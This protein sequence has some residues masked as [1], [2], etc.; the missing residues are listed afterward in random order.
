[1]IQKLLWALLKIGGGVFALYLGLII[2]MYVLQEKLLFLPQPADPQ[3]RR[4][5]QKYQP[6]ALMTTK[7]STG[8]S[9]QGVFVHGEKKPGPLWIYFGGNAEN[10]DYIVHEVRHLKD[11]SFVAFNYRGYGDS[12][13]SPSQRAL[14]QDALHIYD[15]FSKKEGVDPTQIYVIGRSL[16]TGMATYLA[17]HRKVKKVVLISP[18]SSIRDVAQ[19]HYPFLPVKWLIRHPF[20]SDKWAKKVDVPLLCVVA[21][22]DQV[23]PR[24]FSEALFAAW[25]GQKS[26]KLVK[27][28]DH[29][30]IIAAPGH[31]STIQ[32][33]LQEDKK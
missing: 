14:Y 17:A 3:V 7:T 15:T 22:R 25:K 21:E 5:L 11:A 9:L 26:M 2:L 1:M 12:E 28:Y 27:G 23:V 10:I 16:G 32:S 31:W 30:S 4:Y 19:A 24:R 33:F 20:P 18:Y 6:H 29:N 8:E 13:G